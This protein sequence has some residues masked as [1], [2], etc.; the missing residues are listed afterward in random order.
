MQCDC[1]LQ[2][3]QMATGQKEAA[4]ARAS[5]SLRLHAQIM[6]A[7]QKLQKALADTQ[8]WEEQVGSFTPGAHIVVASVLEIGTSPDNAS[9]L[10]AC[11]FPSTTC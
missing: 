6:R 5:E 4:T 8:H 7:Q 2:A 11:S 9:D 1:M 3:G 10:L